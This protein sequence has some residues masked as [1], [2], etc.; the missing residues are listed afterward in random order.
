MTT[1]PTE[2]AS[3]V[4]LVRSYFV[5]E[6][7]ELRSTRFHPRLEVVAL[8]GRLLLNGLSVNY[9]F[10]S[11]H[12]VFEEAFT[13]LKIGEENIETALVLGMGAG[14]VVE[15]LRG[16]PRPPSAITAVEIDPVVVEIAKKHFRIDRHPGL[17]I[18]TMDAAEY[19]ATARA[20]F[21]LAVVD[22]FIDAEIP[23]AFQTPEFLRAVRDRLNPGGLLVYNCMAH[24]EAAIAR[25]ADF[26]RLL[27][28]TLGG[29]MSLR[30][31]GNLILA[32][33]RPRA[34]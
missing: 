32:H 13:R 17:E 29:A 31:Q 4:R 24:N 7:V 16:L 12:R 1:P 21:D 3:L 30:V 19:V 22:L 23:A 6:L 34:D 20:T 14:S 9:S 5:K 18:V 33:R 10:G 27:A 25:S 28:Q 2:F 8:N 15:L 11:L 26:E